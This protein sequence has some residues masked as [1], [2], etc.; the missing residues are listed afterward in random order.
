VRVAMIFVEGVLA[1]ERSKNLM[2]C[3]P[4]PAGVLLWRSLR[5]HYEIVVASTRYDTEKVKLW[6][7]REHIIKVLRVFTSDDI[8]VTSETLLKPVYAELYRVARTKGHDLQLVVTGDPL[9]ARD[10]FQAG[11]QTLFSIAPSFG[12]PEW[13]P[14]YDGSP[15]P[16]DE[17]V[18]EVELG[19][20]ALRPST[21][22]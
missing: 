14:D 22:E 6:I 18:E 16:W 8:P 17:L 10:G 1:E 12:R 11:V 4:S 15:K 5:E 13:R 21:D 7:E 20:A 2:E 9:A 19:R 3:P